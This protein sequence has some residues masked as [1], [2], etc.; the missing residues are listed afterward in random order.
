[1]LIFELQIRIALETSGLGFQHLRAGNTFSTCDHMELRK[2]FGI[3]QQQK[4][5]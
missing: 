5:C 2:S 1:M 4:Q 3:L